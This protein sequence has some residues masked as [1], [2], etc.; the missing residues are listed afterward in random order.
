[1]WD[2]ISMVDNQF[3][4]WKLTLWDKIDTD[5]LVAQI[6]EIQTKQTNP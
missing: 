6:K 1:M 3:N 4:A 5:S 2:L